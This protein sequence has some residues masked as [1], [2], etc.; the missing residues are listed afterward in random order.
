MA[1]RT[2]VLV[3][4]PE[5]RHVVDRA[6][7]ADWRLAYTKCGRRFAWGPPVKPR[8]KVAPKACARCALLA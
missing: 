4:E 1:S 8:P 2:V 6:D 5:T 3:I 7:P